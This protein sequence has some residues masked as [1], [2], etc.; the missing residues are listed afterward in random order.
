M[1]VAVSIAGS[2]SG[3]G[4][5]IQ[6]DLKTFSALG[7]YGCTAITAIT[8][9]NTRGV[10]AI[11]EV[12]PQIIEKQ[13]KSILIDMPPNAI[14]VGMVYSKNIIQTLTKAMQE[15]NC[16]VILDPIFVAGTGANLLLNNAI[17]AFIAELIPLSTLITPNRLEAGKLA[18]RK[19][20]S[21]ADAI[22]AAHAIRKLG[23]KNVII[24][25]NH[26]DKSKSI[27][28]LFLDSEGKP[29]K[30]SNPSQHVKEIHGAGCNFS[31]ASAAF[32]ARGFNLLQ[33]CRLA[34]QYVHQ[35]I[36]NV[37]KIGHGILVT[38]PISNM[39][40]DANC[41]NVLRELQLVI[42][43]M[44]MVNNFGKVIPETQSNFVYA[45]PDAKSGLD[46]AAV[47][48]R[49]ARIESSARAISCVEF[50]ASNH[51]SS[52]VLS[53]MKVDPTIRSA[54]NI[55]LDEKILSVCKSLF[56]LSEYDRVNEP[57]H[58][59]KK[60]GSSIFWGT[61]DALI[62]KPGAQVIYHKGDIGKEPMIMIFGGDPWEV[63]GKILR[64]LRKL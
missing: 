42:H 39:Y 21:E 47:K 46:V 50:G 7:V 32:V 44:E 26:F 49:I 29:A 3:G 51:V 56:E 14:K 10:S 16:P 4:A 11:S 2:D 58:V 55:K 59:K 8:A 20:T 23:A 24:K 57:A 22:E 38:N 30:F 12:D 31:A 33:S 40:H 63:F 18:N 52:A 27:T 35:A 1:K 45:L 43:K 41:Y 15:V 54:M 17:K 6:A 28:D 61:M 64:V 34:N 53:Y 5:G 13:I 36:K 37:L 48:G 62:R 60:E 19:I 25:G 9:Q